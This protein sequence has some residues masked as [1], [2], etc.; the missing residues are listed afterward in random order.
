MSNSFPIQQITL[1]SYNIEF[2]LQRNPQV[3]QGY[4]D[5][6]GQFKN[7]VTISPPTVQLYIDKSC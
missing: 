4:S 7:C 5:A 3:K 6:N 2:V 1:V